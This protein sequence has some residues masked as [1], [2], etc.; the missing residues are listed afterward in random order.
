M[1]VTPLS[2]DESISLDWQELLARLATFATADLTREKIRGLRA[3]SSP[4]EARQSMREIESWSRLLAAGMRPQMTSLDLFTQWHQ[5]LARNAVLRTIELKDVRHF[6][7]EV[8]TLREVIEEMAI[9]SLRDVH[10]KL[11]RADEPLAAIDQILTPAGDIRTD[12]SERLYQLNA[13]KTQLAR[14]VQLILDRLVKSF[15]IEH[16]VQDRYV[17]T[18]EGRWVLP[19]KSGMQ[20]GFEGIIHDSSQTKQTVFMEPQETI[21]IN[22]RLREIEIAFEEE[23]ERLLTELS[24]Y[25]ATL[26]FQF[27]DSKQIMLNADARLAQAK[28]A[29]LMQATTCEF[30]NANPEELSDSNA[31]I[32]GLYLRDLRH[33]LLVINGVPVVANTVE[34]APERRILLLS[35]PNA[36][37]KTVLLKA[38]GLAA[39]MARAGLFICASDGSRLPFFSTMVVALG[40]SQSVDANLSTFAAHL[41]A[42]ERAANV[43]G[44]DTLVLI[45]EICGSTD[46]EE[47]AAL[48]RSFI[49][50]YKDNA[51]FGVITSH[52]GALKH[53]WP[54]G[55]INGSLEFNQKRGPT[56]RFIMGVPGP[57]LALQTAERIGVDRTI[58]DR[59][60][61][62]LSPEAR[63]YQNALSE[64]EQMKKDLLNLNDDVRA[65]QMEAEKSRSELE[66]ARE[67]FEKEK[68]EMLQKELKKA[69]ARIESLI[70]E[71]KAQE[72]FSHHERLSQI[73]QELPTIIKAGETAPS[74]NRIKKTASGAF[75]SADDFSRQCPPGTG[76]Y[77]KSLDRNGIVQGRPNSKGDVPVL[78]SSMRLMISWRDLKP[79]VDS[80]TISKWLGKTSGFVSKSAE[81]DR[82]VDLRGL[83]VEEAISTLEIQLDAAA[84]GNVD[85]V[86]IIHGHGA[87][88][89]LKRGVRTYLSRSVYVKKWQ[90]GTKETGGDGVTW[91]ELK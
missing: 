72:I 21:P 6:C 38:V 69:E 3:L 19:I 91:I 28:I 77:I 18:R 5:R 65:R 46:P 42:L 68:D 15:Q 50:R 78:S 56:Y 66:L 59:A 51:S 82:V 67:K 80:G 33:P 22:N 85:R 26:R 47:G 53:G 63:Q 34:L 32:A 43:Q 62:Y 1:T 27:E 10:E 74:G 75:A 88:D 29:E 55:V 35:G 86:K 17:T 71:T 12:A 73:K 14:Q 8:V 2:V 61:H 58:V 52:L 70:Q 31:S 48:A 87:A 20:H 25:L 79:S 64:I 76:V 81:T 60:K 37:G 13:E 23:I 45:D 90:A 49:D 54:D 16:L 57:S 30:T 83:T 4:Q 44:E 36:G 39:Q 7:Q 9:S 84:L 41:R 40:D 89:M 11:M 24:K